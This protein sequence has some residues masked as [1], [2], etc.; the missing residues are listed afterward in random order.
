MQLQ[1]LHGPPASGKLTIARIVAERP[2][3]A[4]FHNHLIVDAVAAVFPFGAAPF[5][6][7]RERFWLDTIA[8]AAEADRSILFTFAPE[9]SVAPDFAGRLV[10][11]VERRGGRVV[12][13]ALDVGEADQK[14]RLIAEDRARFGRLRSA[15]LL[16]TLRPAMAACARAVPPAMLRI[17]TS[18]M[19]PDEAADAI[20]RLDAV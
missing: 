6:T 19:A 14:S 4:L 7:L 15:E 17:D 13:V 8:A 3:F 2:G 18:R 1:F 16:R 5:V 20:V 11:T 12:T 9:P 10:G